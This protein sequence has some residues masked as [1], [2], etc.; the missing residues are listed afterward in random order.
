[1]LGELAPKVEVIETREI[2]EEER[3]RST[4]SKGNNEDDDIDDE[5]S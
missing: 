2:K 1:M 4:P 5:N 3:S